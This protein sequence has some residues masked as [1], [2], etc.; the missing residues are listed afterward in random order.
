M[1]SFPKNNQFFDKPV[2]LCGR[3]NIKTHF[4]KQSNYKNELIY[5][6]DE[7]SQL[8]DKDIEQ[9]LYLDINENIMKELLPF[10]MLFLIESFMILSPLSLDK[11][12]ERVGLYSA[13][14]DLN[15]CNASF[16]SLTA[17]IRIGEL[18][19]NITDI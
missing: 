15:K 7:E 13:K 16:N 9:R 10:D 2:D 12:S 6:F 1:I 5:S 14:N 4:I 8:L 19:G 11:M 3:I 18:F 17:G